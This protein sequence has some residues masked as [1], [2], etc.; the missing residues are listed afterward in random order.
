MRCI[1]LISKL[2]S[3]LHKWLWQCSPAT[4]LLYLAVIDVAGAIRIAKIVVRMSTEYSEKNEVP[5]LAAF[6]F[7]LGIFLLGK[8]ASVILIVLILLAC[9]LV[10]HQAVWAL[11]VYQ[12]VS[13]TTV[14]TYVMA[15]KYD[16][17]EKEQRAA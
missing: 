8:V 7:Y 15:S 16:T 13:I 9:L 11:V 17:N 2:S 3:K 12:V 1:N 14:I 5:V 4:Y 10:T 6:D